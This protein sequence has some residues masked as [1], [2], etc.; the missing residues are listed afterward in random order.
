MDIFHF[1]CNS[2]SGYLLFWSFSFGLFSTPF[3]LSSHHHHHQERR[4][5]DCTLFLLFLFP[6]ALSFSL[7]VLTILQLRSFYPLCVSLSLSLFLLLRFLCTY[8]QT[9]THLFYIDAS[10]P[11]TNLSIELT[12]T[13]DYVR[14]FTSLVVCMSSFGTL[15]DI[16]ISLRWIKSRSLFSYRSTTPMLLLLPFLL[17]RWLTYRVSNSCHHYCVQLSKHQTSIRLN[18]RPIDQSSH[19]LRLVDMPIDK[20]KITNPTTDSTWLSSMF[21]SSHSLYLVLIFLSLAWNAYN[22]HQYQTLLTRQSK[23]ESSLEELGFSVVETRTSHSMEQWYS[24]MLDLIRQWTSK[25]APSRPNEDFKAQSTSVRFVLLEMP[26]ESLDT[27]VWFL[28]R[29]RSR[30]RHSPIPLFQTCITN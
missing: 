16:L 21:A 27:C 12:H 26:L 8:T 6:L 30:S 17:W 3:P 24:Q 13:S 15:H 19:L 29:S 1:N 10:S 4:R 7:S 5:D 9:Y 22:T 2:S 18:Q 28:S 25:E 14:P 23:L 11:K 20:R